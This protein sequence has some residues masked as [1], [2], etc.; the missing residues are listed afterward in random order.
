MSANIYTTLAL[1]FSIIL[2][3]ISA[4]RGTYGTR[5][6]QSSSHVLNGQITMMTNILVEGSS[7]TGKTLLCSQIV[8]T[9]ISQFEK[10]RKPEDK[11]VRVIVTQYL[12]SDEGDPLL[13]NFREHYF[14]NIDVNIL[15]IQPFK[16]LA[17]DHCVDVDFKHPKAAMTK[18][19]N[20]LSSSDKLTILLVDELWACDDEGQVSA[21][22]SDLPTAPNVV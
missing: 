18:I 20:S 11:P 12:A 17:E 3:V 19:I 8:K 14:A 10:D 13:N 22:W 21:D 2:Y 5:K 1:N 7:G 4:D 9:K 16:K 15:N 6:T